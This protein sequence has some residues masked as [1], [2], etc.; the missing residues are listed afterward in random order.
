MSC[1]RTV[2]GP[3]TPAVLASLQS[4]CAG[5]RTRWIHHPS[6]AH[7]INRRR[8]SAGRYGFGP[9]S[10]A[11]KNE[12]LQRGCVMSALDGCS[13]IPGPPPLPPRDLVARRSPAAKLLRLVLAPSLPGA[14]RCAPGAGNTY[15]SVRPPRQRGFVTSGFRQGFGRGA[16]VRKA[17]GMALYM[18]PTPRPPVARGKA[19]AGGCQQLT[20]GA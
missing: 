17:C 1:R 6:Q 19:M 12:A 15:A 7:P 18:F 11:G 9:G 2:F 5:V 8:P 10:P 20:D 13:T 16:H 4:G 3:G 14:L